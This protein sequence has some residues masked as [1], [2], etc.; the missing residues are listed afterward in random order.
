MFI[1]IVFGLGCDRPSGLLLF[2]PALLPSF[3]TH[4]SLLTFF[5]CFF[6]LFHSCR[7]H[8]GVFGKTLVHEF[9][10]SYSHT[11]WYL[12]FY[13]FGARVYKQALLL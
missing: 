8:A 11:E 6:V 10:V 4:T 5:P 12:L 3:H 2:V 7:S 1:N 9:P 13:L